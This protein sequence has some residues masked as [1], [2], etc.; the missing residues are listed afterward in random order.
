MPSE[1]PAVPES[2]SGIFLVTHDDEG[3][4]IL[5]DVGSGRIHPVPEDTDLID[6]DAFTGTIESIPPLGVLWE[7]HEKQDSWSISLERGQNPPTSEE[8]DIATATSQGAVHTECRG[9]HELHVMAIEDRDESAVAEEII[10]DEETKARAARLEANR[11]VVRT[12]DGLV[13]VTYYY[14]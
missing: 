4:T 14:R 3:G 10:E 13:T 7:I 6:G 8:Q 9:D 12:G 5:Q 11:V 1:E 2:V